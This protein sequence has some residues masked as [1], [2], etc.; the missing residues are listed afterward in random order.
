MENTYQIAIS[1]LA[2]IIAMAATWFAYDQGY[3]DPVIEK[4]GYVSHGF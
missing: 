4:F 1:L 2:V 3:L